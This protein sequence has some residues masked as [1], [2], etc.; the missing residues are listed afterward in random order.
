M[1]ITRSRVDQQTSS[2]FFNSS[3]E[4]HNLFPL[5]V[6]QMENPQHILKKKVLSV[7]SNNHLCCMVLIEFFMIRVSVRLSDLYTGKRK[8]K[9]SKIATVG[10]E[11]RT[12]G[13][14]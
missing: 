7:I 9:S 11:I 2:H 14:C 6:F 10:I 8:K 13:S 1:Y 3:V 12:S 5:L 4:I